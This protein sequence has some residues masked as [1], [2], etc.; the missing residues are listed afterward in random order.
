MY[1]IIANRRLRA[2]VLETEDGKL[3][4]SWGPEMVRTTIKEEDLQKVRPSELGGLI[5]YY[6]RYDPPLEIEKLED[7]PAAVQRAREQSKTAHIGS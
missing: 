5:R 1:K 2:A 4:F 6:T 3:H 7:W